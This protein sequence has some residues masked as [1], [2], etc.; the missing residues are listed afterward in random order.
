[1]SLQQCPQLSDVAQPQLGAPFPLLLEDEAP[2]QVPDL[3][4]PPGKPSPM[5][6]LFYRWR[7][8][9]W[10]PFPHGWFMTLV[11]PHQRGSVDSDNNRNDKGN[12]KRDISSK[13]TNNIN[14]NKNN[15]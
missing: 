3:K 15:I 9:A 10:L 4:E 1:M 12:D 14:N 7:D 5:T 8:V 6:H 11:Q 13:D 2:F